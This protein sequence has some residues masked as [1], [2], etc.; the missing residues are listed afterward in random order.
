MACL[1]HQDDE[2]ATTR[3]KNRVRIRNTVIL[4]SKNGPPPA[5]AVAGSL[6]ETLDVRGRC[7]QNLP[8]TRSEEAAMTDF[9]K[10]ENNTPSEA[11]SFKW[12][13]DHEVSCRYA[14]SYQAASRRR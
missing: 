10:E 12:L 4:P 14:R 7:P 5:F 13:V 1:V 2:K 3:K 6:D 9:C 11:T 8:A